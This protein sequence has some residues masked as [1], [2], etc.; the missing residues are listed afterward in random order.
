MYV[1]SGGGVI[2]SILFGCREVD[3]KRLH[4]SFEVEIKSRFRSWLYAWALPEFHCLLVCYL[5]QNST[6]ITVFHF[7]LHSEDG[8]GITMQGKYRGD[9]CLVC[10]EELRVAQ[11]ACPPSAPCAGG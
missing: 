10:V 3:R 7:F 8:F 2:G 4:V 6:R 9:V 5:V 11:R 1:D